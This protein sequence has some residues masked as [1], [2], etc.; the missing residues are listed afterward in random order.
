MFSTSD[1]ARLRS[2]HNYYSVLRVQVKRAA[3][4][5]VPAGVEDGQTLRTQVDGKEFFLKF[6]VEKSSKFRRQGSDI[7]S[8]LAVSLSQGN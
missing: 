1:K 5:Q 6:S 2:K 7:H 8:D 3:E 4:I